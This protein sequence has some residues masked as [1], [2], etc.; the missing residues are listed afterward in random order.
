MF[1]HNCGRDTVI[2][3]F[4]GGVMGDLCGYVAAGYMRGIPFI[5]L[6]TSFLAMVDSSIGGKTGIDTPAGKNLLGAF[7]RPLA[8]LIDLSLLL[9]L[10][11]RELCNGMAESIKAGLIASAELFELME[12]NADALLKDKDL[13]LLAEV[14]R[15]SVAIKAHVVLNDEREAGLRSILNFGHS[16]GHAI[17]ALSLPHLL[18]GECVAIGMMEEIILARGYGLVGSGELR[19]VDNI[20]R[21]YS[22][23]TR[24]PLHLSP[25][26]L[27]DK[28]SI[29]KKVRWLASFNGLCAHRWS[30]RCVSRLAHVTFAWPSFLRCL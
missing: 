22:L 25:K 14:V 7:H 24:V 4:G 30:G 15:R 19:R 5:Q 21:A 12:Q 23:P 8:V 10:P 29:D 16:I 17:E 28:M 3:A 2:L 1:S 11:Q 6:P 20:L 13:A 9:T 18:H 26:A 27:V